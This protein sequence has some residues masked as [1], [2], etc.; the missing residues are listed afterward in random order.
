LKCAK[1]LDKVA[2]QSGTEVSCEGEE[3]RRRPTTDP[4]FT[5]VLGYINPGGG[6]HRALRR[7]DVIHS[8]P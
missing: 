4:Q 1:F 3:E 7:P 2:S 8:L 6:A 5:H